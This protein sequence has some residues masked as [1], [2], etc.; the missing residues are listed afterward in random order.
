MYNN[1]QVTID[2]PF[3]REL[4]GAPIHSSSYATQANK[5][6]ANILENGGAEDYFAVYLV[7]EASFSVGRG[8]ALFAP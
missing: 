8:L 2:Y 5:I 7:H 6:G 4:E 1:H 3:P